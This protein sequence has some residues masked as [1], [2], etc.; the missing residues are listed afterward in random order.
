MTTRPLSARP[1]PTALR[2]TRLVSLLA[3]AASLAL[4]VT[5]FNVITDAGP[6]GAASRAAERPAAVTHAMQG[7]AMAAANYELP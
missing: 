4:V 5:G 1:R 2:K 6:A 3:F 7:H